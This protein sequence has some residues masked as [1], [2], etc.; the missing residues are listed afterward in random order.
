[1]PFII[2]TYTSMTSLDSFFMETSPGVANVRVSNTAYCMEAITA[3]TY[4]Y[5]K[6]YN[7]LIIPSTGDTTVVIFE[8]KNDYEEDIITDLKEFTTSLVD[9]QLREFLNKKYGRIRDLIVEHAF[10]P[11]DLKKELNTLA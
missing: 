7:I 9:H 2:K 1:M 11:I 4:P 6:K 5:G 8:K 3:A 10:K